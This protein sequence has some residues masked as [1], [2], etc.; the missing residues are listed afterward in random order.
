MKFAHAEC[1]A[2]AIIEAGCIFF[3]RNA[4]PARTFS[5]A[6]SYMLLPWWLSAPCAFCDGGSRALSSPPTRSVS[7]FSRQLRSC[8][9]RDERES[10]RRYSVLFRCLIVAYFCFFLLLFALLAAAPLDGCTFVAV[11][12]LGVLVVLLW[13]HHFIRFHP[14]LFAAAL[15]QSDLVQTHR[16]VAPVANILKTTHE[17]LPVSPPYGGLSLTLFGVSTLAR[18]VLLFF[19]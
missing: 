12:D 2:P 19:L 16:G 1:N 10:V 14:A 17:V 4:Y 7:M 5:T 9:L 15:R 6:A 8:A 3:E 18:P 11:S 13:I